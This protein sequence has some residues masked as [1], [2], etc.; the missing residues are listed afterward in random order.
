[1]ARIM[2]PYSQAE[3]D[4]MA[5]STESAAVESKRKSEWQRRGFFKDGKPMLRREVALRASNT[6]LW[7]EFLLHAGP[8]PSRE[9]YRLAKLEGISARGVRRAKRYHG[10]RQAPET[11]PLKTK[12]RCDRM[13]PLQIIRA[14]H[15]TFEESWQNWL[16][17]RS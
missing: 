6:R 4:R 8:L 17:H 5:A 15:H 16:L 2:F 14:F 12:I 11:Q 9:V 1:M 7:L 3:L 13:R 10:M